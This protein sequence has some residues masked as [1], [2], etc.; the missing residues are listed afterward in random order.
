MW[1]SHLISSHLISS[2]L[3]SSHLISSHLISSHLISSHL[4]SSHLISSHLISSCE[5]AGT[6]TELPA[7]LKPSPSVP[8]PRKRKAAPVVVNQIVPK[9][10]GHPV[11]SM[12]ASLPA[13]DRSQ[14]TFDIGAA[15]ARLTSGACTGLQITAQAPLGH[16]GSLAHHSTSAAG[17]LLREGLDMNGNWPQAC[18]SPAEPE[19]HAGLK[20][21]SPGA[22]PENILPPVRLEA[23]ASSAISAWNTP[24]A[25]GV[26]N[27]CSSRCGS[28][29][30]RMCTCLQTAQSPA[31]MH[32]G[33]QSDWVHWEAA[34]VLHKD[35]HDQARKTPPI[36]LEMPQH[37]QDAT[38]AA[39]GSQS[40][41]RTRRKLWQSVS[42]QHKCGFCKYC[43]HPEMKQA[44]ITRRQ[45]QAAQLVR[46]AHLPL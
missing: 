41:K 7:W 40:I 11:L 1:S 44:C 3:I 46:P 24:S 13:L 9:Q 15:P 10:L 29:T 21:I 8:G 37:L 45:E 39:V 18:A 20:V 31:G 43:L 2:H 38:D 17:P 35:N 12:H 30:S 14:S 19:K 42:K 36:V 5:N 22:A 26:W 4:I 23:Q 32:L 27:L 28:C 6:P 16:P 25:D 34:Q 33:S